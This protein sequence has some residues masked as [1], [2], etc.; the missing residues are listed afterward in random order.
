MNTSGRA[1]AYLASAIRLLLL[2]FQYLLRYHLFAGEERS[3][4]APRI[5]S[6]LS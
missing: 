2:V 1:R 4:A 3:T 5:F 6:D